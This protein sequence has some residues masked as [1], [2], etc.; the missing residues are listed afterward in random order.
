MTLS[1][2][3]QLAAA[4]G[5]GGTG[6]SGAGG[7][8]ITLTKTSPHIHTIT[9]DYPSVAFDA[10]D[11][12][13]TGAGTT[14][15]WSSGDPTLLHIER[16]SLVFIDASARGL[17]APTAGQISLYIQVT[18]SGVDSYFNLVPQIISPADGDVYEV[19]RGLMLPLSAGD[20][21][22]FGTGVDTSDTPELSRSVLAAVAVS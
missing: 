10:G 19:A 20:V 5:G 8:L 2:L 12:D 16:D 1:K 13:V 15:S 9:S 11:S 3:D 6:T 18:R 4:P 21:V 17:G 14:F 7:D 22:Q